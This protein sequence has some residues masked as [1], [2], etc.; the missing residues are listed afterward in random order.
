[1]PKPIDPTDIGKIPSEHAQ[2]VAVFVWAALN[3][4]KY[5]ELRLMFAIPNGGERNKIVAANLKAEGVRA[6]VPDI[7]LPVPRARW[8][9]LFIE[10]KKVGGRVDPGQDE[11]INKLR[12]QKYGACVCVGWQEAVQT[13]TNYLEWGK[14]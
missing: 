6:H 11:F 13:I 12:E 5:P 9:G 1:M 3:F 10:M 14:R 4:E 8:H 2:Q 7:F